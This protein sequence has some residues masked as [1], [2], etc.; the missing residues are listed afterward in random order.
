MLNPDLIKRG[1]DDDEYATACP[2]LGTLM[3]AH[4][5]TPEAHR[6]DIYEADCQFFATHIDRRIYLRPTF[7]MEHDIDERETQNIE[8]PTLWVS[9]TQLAPGFHMLLP[10]WRGRSFW[11]GP[12]SDSDAGVGALLL[13]MSLRG[14]LNIAEW[15][16][17]VSDQR[18]RKADKARDHK[19]KKALVN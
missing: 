2:T 12:Q 7:R 3:V 16:S 10:V 1:I 19:R 18:V 14:G 11:N 15:Y 6:K 9:V 17:Y 4:F 8:R 13:Q 5:S